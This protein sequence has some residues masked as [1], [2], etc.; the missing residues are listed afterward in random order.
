MQIR[1]ITKKENVAM[2]HVIRSSL[3]AYGLALPGTVYYDAN[4][5]TLSAS[6]DHEGCA[7]YVLIDGN[8]VLGGAGYDRF[9]GFESCCEIQK[10]YVSETVRG[11]GYGKQ[12]LLFVMEQAQKAGYDHCYIETHDQLQEALGL[13]KKTGLSGD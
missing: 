3:E 9:V 11:H 4:L 2:A 7:Y 13:Y 1:K 10:L 8:S 5:E 12:L 6:Y